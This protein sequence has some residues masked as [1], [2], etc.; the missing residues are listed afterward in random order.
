MSRRAKF[1]VGL[2]GALTANSTTER[3]IA[4]VLAHAEGR[5][6]R[7]ALFAGRDI[8]LPMYAPGE[9]NR[10]QAAER[11]VAA[12]RRADGVVIGSPGYHGS[13]SGLVKN[14]LDY[15]ED[16]ARDSRPYF[17]GRPIACVATGAGWQGANMTLQALRSIAH[18]LRGW[19]TSLGLALNTR[20]PLFDK[21]GTCLAAEADAQFGL[22]ADQLMGFSSPH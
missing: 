10:T 14:A 7:T 2:G 3:A 6:A 5:G 21:E 9:A 22:V 8:D 13:V 12:L 16:L 11:M 19:P 20:D 1:I 17:T 15:V 18:A 4:R